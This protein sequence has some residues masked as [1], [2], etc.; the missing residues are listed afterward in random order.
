MT[1]IIYSPLEGSGVVASDSQETGE[2]RKSTCDK[3]YRVNNHIIG[4]AGGSYAG[5]LFVRWFREWED[6]PNYD[7]WE[8]HPDLI[9][10]PEDEDFECLVVRPDWSCYTINRLFIPYEMKDGFVGVGSGA[11]PALGAL[12]AGAT[13][14]EAVR[15]ACKID[16]HSSGPIKVM[17]VRS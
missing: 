14:R 11:G 9:S 10:L 6:E 15:I 3:L 13:C 5:L 1:T 4:T 2:T 16:A 8:D 17:K 12:H 7:D